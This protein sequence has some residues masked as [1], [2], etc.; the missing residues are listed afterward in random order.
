MGGG[1][2]RRRFLGAA[3]AVG[4]AAAIGRPAWTR[5]QAQVTSGATT[6]RFV[7]DPYVTCFYQWNKD[8]L[9]I[10]SGEKGLKNGDGYLH[11]MTRSHAAHDPH[12]EAARQ[13]HDCGASFKYARAIDIWKYKGWQEATD[14]Q[15][16]QWAIEFRKEALPKGAESDYFA[17]NE[18]P[19]NAE[20]M[21]EWRR[22]CA[23]WVR[24][25]HDPN[26]G[27]PKLKGVFYL[28]EEN[29]V[30]D[31]WKGEGIDDFWDAVNETSVLVV[32]EH[33][34]NKKFLAEN[35][36]EQ[37]AA[38]LEALPKWLDASGKPSQRDIAMRKYAVLHSTYY[39]PNKT[40]WEGLQS[41]EATEADF[42]DYLR[43]L[44]KY[45]RMSPYGKRRIAFGPLQT[46]DID[47]KVVTA[48]VAEVLREEM[49]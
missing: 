36:A 15:L 18:F 27:G 49:P 14:D 9:A 20:S 6:D 29:C 41:G 32:G 44:I 39:G 22:R 10:L 26:D 40:N 42:R 31:R 45:T 8:A 1:L 30:P 7:R 3:G 34:H 17:F 5:A 38:H 37:Y 48:A 43:K 13:V 47:T 16:R 28:V 4:A 2:S 11:L 19:T 46:K 24:Y 33:Y 25:I 21:P 23:Q 12:P 35:S